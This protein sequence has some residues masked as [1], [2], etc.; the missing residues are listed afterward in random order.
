MGWC[1]FPHSHETIHHPC[2]EASYLFPLWKENP[3]ISYLLRELTIL[4][5]PRQTPLENLDFLVLM[6]ALFLQRKIKTFP[7]GYAITDINVFLKF[8]LLTEL[9]QFLWLNELL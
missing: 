6:D 4:L 3:L 9:N 8:K 1:C 5:S 2:S 7:V